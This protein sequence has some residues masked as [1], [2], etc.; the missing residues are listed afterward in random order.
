MYGQSYNQKKYCR[1]DLSEVC[2]LI[3]V[4]FRHFVWVKRQYLF[5]G[6]AALAGC[7]ITH[8]LLLQC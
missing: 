7:Y 1:A 8:S 5:F 4:R 2:L 3:F 6:I